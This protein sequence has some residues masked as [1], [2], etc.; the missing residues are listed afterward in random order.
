METTTQLGKLEVIGYY[1]KDYKKHY[2]TTRE[3]T[4]AMKQLYLDNNFK[5]PEA[6][7]LKVTSKTQ[8]YGDTSECNVA[9]THNFRVS[10]RKARLV[11]T[12]HV[13]DFNG[14]KGIWWNLEAAKLY[15]PTPPPKIEIDSDSDNE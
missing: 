12:P 11:A 5:V 9:V 14:K 10:R 7:K 2:L 8:F 13:Y 3:P 15:A 6:I 4:S 1:A